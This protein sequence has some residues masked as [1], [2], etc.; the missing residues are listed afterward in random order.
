MAAPD[1]TAGTVMNKAASLMN[2]T[3]LSV[4]T[5]AAQLPYLNIAMQ[6]LQEHFELNAIPMTEV[7]SS[8]INMP[9]GSDEIIYNGVGVPTLPDDMVE[10]NQLW[11]R[12]E[13]INPFVPMT[14]RDYLP[15]N[16]E[17]IETNQ[18]IYYAWQGQKILVLPAN[19][20]NDIKIDY[21]RELFTEAT[22][23]GSLINV[24]NAASFLEY[25][26]AGL[27]A[28]FIERNVTSANALNAYSVLALDR[29][30]GIGVRGKQSIM[31]RRRPFRAA[32]KRG[33]WVT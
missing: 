30:T 29:V 9:A 8:V 32:Y 22:G 18:F 21:I 1:L 17:G 20:N 15:H 27:L 13:N 10:P 23:P 12:A 14:R 25:R 24:V 6:E 26:T 19:Q 3:A 11:E 28:E 33:G 31:T 7:V 4:Y 2:D 5:Y 16:L